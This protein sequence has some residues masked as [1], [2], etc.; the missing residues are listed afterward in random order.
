M[1][2]GHRAVSHKNFARL[3]LTSMDWLKRTMTP[4]VEKDCVTSGK[5]QESIY[6]Y[7]SIVRQ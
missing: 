5:F 7:I 6:R 1:P 2:E 4:F 3:L